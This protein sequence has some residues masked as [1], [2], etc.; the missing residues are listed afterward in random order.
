MRDAALAVQSYA[1]ITYK[2]GNLRMA[3]RG[4]H[5]QTQRDFLRGDFVLL[6]EMVFLFKARLNFPNDY[7][8]F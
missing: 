6:L 7:E 3:D 5:N 4:L 8:E 2:I 1:V